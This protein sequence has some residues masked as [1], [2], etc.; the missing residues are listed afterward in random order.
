[1]KER[2]KGQPESVNIDAE[3]RRLQRI[4]LDVLEKTPE[5]VRALTSIYLAR[6]GNCEI[7]GFPR[8]LDNWTV[9]YGNGVLDL[10]VSGRKKD[11][12]SNSEATVLHVGGKDGGPATSS[13]KHIIM[14]ESFRLK[15]NAGLEEM[16]AK[17]LR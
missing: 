4:I 12:K 2:D 6:D 17:G 1:M 10:D 7:V 8:G 16:K 3:A 15:P 9:S 14:G 5:F 11:G 13:I